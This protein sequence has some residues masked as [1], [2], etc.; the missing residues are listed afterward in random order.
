M[1]NNKKSI[2]VIVLLF[3]GFT[4]LP[5]LGPCGTV[6]ALHEDFQPPEL[7][8]YPS[9]DGLAAHEA[10]SPI[11][12]AAGPNPG[13]RQVQDRYSTFK[14]RADGAV[15]YCADSGSANDDPGG[16][17]ED[18]P[19]DPEWQPSTASATVNPLSPGGTIADTTPTYK[20]TRE[21]GATQYRFQLMQGTTTVYTKTVSSSAC[22]ASTCTNTPVTALGYAS[23]KWRVQAMVSNV[24][25]AYSTF[26]TFTVI[27]PVPTPKAPVGTIVDTTP[28]YTW[29]RIP[30]ATQYRFQL[31][32]GT[33]IVCTKTV[34]SS[35]CGASTCANT[36][37]APLGYATYRWRVQAM[38]D[39][40]WK[41]YSAFKTFT[42][43]DCS[44]VLLPAATGGCTF[45]LATPTVC[46]E[47]DLTNGKSYEFGWTTDGDWCETPWTLCMAG[48]PA[49]TET[50]S[51]IY[52][53]DFSAGSSDYIN[54]YGGVVYLDA[55]AFNSLK[56]TTNN[57]IYH[58]VVISFSGAN[59]NSQ[60]FRV[61]K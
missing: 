39:N 3:A 4:I 47:I 27:K 34:A 38:V 1:E 59:P 48:N 20:W 54:H 46:E 5:V 13:M 61:R 31:L 28:T 45:R 51:N 7:Q 56:L 52:C 33:T 42:V 2:F 11:E 21:T 44:V 6:Q 43:A 53:Q 32:K 18:L 50:G 10:A 24:W 26:K 57:G 41:A 36:P 40:A 15:R 19:E 49:D 37:A 23:Y 29:T 25:K 55:A 58:W 22:G 8:F 30:G 17:T 35:A 16:P 9:G 12:V 14:R 60:T